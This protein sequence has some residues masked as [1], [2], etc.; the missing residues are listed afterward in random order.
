MACYKTVL[1]SAWVSVAIFS[2]SLVYRNHSF[3]YAYAQTC[4]FDLWDC[5][6]NINLWDYSVAHLLGG[7]CFRGFSLWDLPLVQHDIPLLLMCS[8]LKAS[9]EWCSSISC[10][11]AGFSSLKV[12]WSCWKDSTVLLCLL[13]QI[14]RNSVVKLLSWFGLIFACSYISSV[15]GAKQCHSSLQVGRLDVWKLLR[16]WQQNWH[17]QRNS[18][19]TL[20]CL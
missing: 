14:L 19:F 13:T 15:H 17:L 11:L 12:W 1:L 16:H 20:F 9:L 8:T 2:S 6:Y 18:W 7:L 3:V 5:D 10:D 4:L